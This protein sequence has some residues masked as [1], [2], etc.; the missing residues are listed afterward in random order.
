M[1]PPGRAGPD[2]TDRPITPSLIYEGK[3]HQ[4]M[5]ERRIRRMRL[6]WKRDLKNK[7]HNLNEVRPSNSIPLL[8]ISLISRTKQLFR[9]TNLLQQDTEG[10][11]PLGSNR[12]LPFT[13]YES[14]ASCLSSLGF[15]S[16]LCK[17]EIMIASLNLIRVKSIRRVKCVNILNAVRTR[18]GTD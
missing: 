1:V 15:S 3:E 10:K 2:H 18:P 8:P 9:R 7:Q 6:R 17:V 11:S 16:F 12:R 14:L 13:I 5:N 4:R